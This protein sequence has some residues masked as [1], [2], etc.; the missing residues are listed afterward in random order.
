VLAIGWV[1]TR[2]GSPS[3]STTTVSGVENP[4]IA[5]A[6]PAALQLACDGLAGALGTS[7]IPL[8]L[9]QIPADTLVINFAGDLAVELGAQSFARSPIAIAIWGE[10]GPTLESNCGAIDVQCLVDNA[11]QTWDE[12]GGPANWGTV[13]IGLADPTEGIADQEAWRLVAATNP[14]PG[15]GEWVR[16]RA[17][18]GGQLV[19]DLV[20]FP[21]RADAV[22][23]SEAAIASQLENARARAGRLTVFYPDPGPF[24]P[25]AAYGE[26]RAARNLVE[27][28]LEPDIQA[29]LGSL[30]LRPTT[31]EATN[32]LRDLG[33]P[34]A[35]LAPVTEAE[36]PALISS[37]Q[38]V[39]G[40]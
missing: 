15:W 25:V 10:R 38:S 16:L 26:G 5:L 2:D 21:S 17:P 31:G 11:G 12:L 18:D 8:P 7:R 40:G 39:V 27:R 3:P 14:P 34:G 1:V 22:V 6:C 33:T 32:L 9:G 28:L 37:W 24:L 4:D 20:L 23:A 30:G 29:L 35:E 36:K 19:A 13:L